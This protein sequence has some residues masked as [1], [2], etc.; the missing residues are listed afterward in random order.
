MSFVHS[1][2]SLTDL[3]GSSPSI[4]CKTVHATI[5]AA[6]FCCNGE[7]PKQDCKADVA[8][9]LFNNNPEQRWQ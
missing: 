7:K 6:S 4:R 8:G 5:V 2:H 3:Y 9:I 1:W